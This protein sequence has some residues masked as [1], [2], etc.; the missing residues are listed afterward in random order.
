MD[1]IPHGGSFHTHSDFGFLHNLTLF[2]LFVFESSLFG[3][4][5]RS[6]LFRLS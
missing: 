4:W 6:I 1:K 2:G 5:F 3:K